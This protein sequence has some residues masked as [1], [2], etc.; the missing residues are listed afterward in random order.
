MYHACQYFESVTMPGMDDRSGK[1]MVLRG[2][3]E[4]VGIQAKVL[5]GRTMGGVEDHYLSD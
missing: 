1:C 2:G 4:N 5:K 3:K